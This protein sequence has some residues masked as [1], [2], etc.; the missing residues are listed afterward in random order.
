MEPGATFCHW[1]G[2]EVG[3]EF[4]ELETQACSKLIFV[5]LPWKRHPRKLLPVGS[6]LKPVALCLKNMETYLQ[7]SG[8]ESPQGKGGTQASKIHRNEERQSS[9]AHPVAF[10]CHLSC[11][12]VAQTMQ[13]LT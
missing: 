4:C 5:P 12:G 13:L 11:S 6:V 10:K 1:P 3:R 8:K 9:R 7:S 2:L